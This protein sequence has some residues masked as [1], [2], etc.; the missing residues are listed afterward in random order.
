[1]ETVKPLLAVLMCLSLVAAAALPARAVENAPVQAGGPA[2]EKA[3]AEK[4]VAAAADTLQLLEKAVA[5]DS[6]RFDDLYK[7]GVLYLD[8]DRVNEAVKVLTKAHAL[9]SKDHRVNVNL[10]AALDAAGRA[11][12][13]QAYY[14]EALQLAPGDS[15]AACRLASSLYSQSKY[16]DAMDQLREVL[17][18]SP[19]AHCAYFTMGVAF[20]DAGMYRDA[21]RMWRKVVELAPTSAEAISARESIE[22]LEKFVRQ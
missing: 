4:A 1:V 15:V 5:R 21:I 19:R 18:Q 3:V 10:G 7:L 16:S 8:K 17:K 6:T 14:R 11:I 2:A 9:R 12:E 22:V 13:A 20:A